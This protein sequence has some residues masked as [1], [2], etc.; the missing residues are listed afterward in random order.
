[1]STMIQTASAAHRGGRS[2]LRVHGFLGAAAMFI[3]ALL[4]PLAGASAQSGDDSAKGGLFFKT[5]KPG[6][7]YEA[8][9]VDTDVALA[10]T[11]TIL[12]ATVRQRFVNPSNAWLEGVYVFPVPEQAAVDHLAMEIGD[13]KVVGEIKERQEAKAV[14]EQAAANGQ[15]ASLVESERPNIFTTSVANIG[16]GEAITVEIQYQDSVHIDAGTYSLRFPMV[17]GPRYIPG[18]PI[19]QVS[20]NPDQP[21]PEP[22]TGWAANTDRVPDASRIT[23]AV[24]QPGQGKINPVRIAIDFAPGFATERVT[25]LYHPVIVTA[26]DHGSARVA[27]ADGD[28][29]AD[30][31]FVLEWTAKPATAPTANL[32]AEQRGPDVYLFAMM[33]PAARDNDAK[34]HIPRDVVFVIDTSGSMGGTSIVQAKSALTL[35]LDRLT[36]DD[37]FNVIQFNSVT[38][39][40]FPDVQPW[41]G[42]TLRRAHAFVD[43]L[44]A[45]GGTEMRPALQQALAGE[46]PAGRLKQIV[47]MTDAA[48]GNEAEMFED[49]ARQLGD[50]RLFT[51]GI[52][53]APNSYFMRKAAELGRGSFTYI[54]DVSEVGERMKELL[55]KLED[56]AVTDIAVRWPDVVA[57]TAEMYPATVPD[58]YDGQPVTFSARLPNARLD[59]L[60]GLL[61]IEGRDGGT[62][63]RQVLDLS[64]ARAGAGVAAVWARAKLSAIEDQ[65]YHGATAETVRLAAI[66][67]ALAYELVSQYTSLVAVDEQRVRPAS[68]RLD[69][70]A[71]ATNL[72]Q[73]WEYDKVFGGDSAGSGGSNAMPLP[74]PGK[75]MR[76]INF[77][78][79]PLDGLSLPKTATPGPLHLLIGALLL[80]L[81]A[82]SLGLGRWRGRMA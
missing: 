44:V 74:E 26:G 63:W 45:T 3:S 49:I 75:L 9:L 13:R 51:I 8:P 43:A 71:V 56:P 22:G 59:Q 34:P 47:F 29:P 70:A 53:S 15:H 21:A 66:R 28:V 27:L 30:R 39:T 14:Y 72:P 32:F 41:T 5:S 4:L 19:A 31:D 24:L 52:G 67:H 48:V 1:M 6:V 64:H 36:A 55:R 50:Q 2:L 54:G 38:E 57:S 80:A 69:T 18:G 16:P 42:D 58:L 25:S 77:T 73:G 37:R 11:G 10:V 60:S 35:A 79:T 61:A 62:A 68:E 65:Q 82:T 23:P 33:T 20:A 17:V 46:T 7:Y 78:G 12:R 76:E 81:A 40:L